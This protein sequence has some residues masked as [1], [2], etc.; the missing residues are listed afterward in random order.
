MKVPSI[1]GALI[2]IQDNIPIHCLTCID[3]CEVFL[4]YST[5]VIWLSPM[6]SENHA[7]FLARGGKDMVHWRR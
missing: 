2:L 5:V 7:P 6:I 3:L 1:L 4:Y